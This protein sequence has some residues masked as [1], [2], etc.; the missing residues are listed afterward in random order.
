MKFVLKTLIAFFIFAG[1]FFVFPLHNAYAHDPGGDCS[2]TRMGPYRCDFFTVYKCAN[3]SC[4]KDGG[5]ID[6][7]TKWYTCENYRWEG[8]GCDEPHDDPPRKVGGPYGPDNIHLY[9]SA[10]DYQICPASGNSWGLVPNVPPPAYQCSG[11][12]YPAPEIT[13]LDKVDAIPE[14]VFEN[15]KEDGPIANPNNVKLPAH[16]SWDDSVEKKLAESPNPHPNTALCK[17]DSYE[18]VIPNPKPGQTELK[19]KT[20]RTNN[21]DVLDVDNNPDTVPRDVIISKNECA[22]NSNAQYEFTVRACLNKEC[23]DKQDT[24]LSFKTSPAPQLLL[25]FDEDFQGEKGAPTPFPAQFKWCSQQDSSRKS[26]AIKAYELKNG[27]KNHL[28]INDLSLQKDQTTY[29]DSSR[30]KEGFE[31]FEKGARYFWKIGACTDSRATQCGI[32]SQLWSIITEGKL[33]APKNLLPASSSY[34]N[35]NDVLE[36]TNPVFTTNFVIHLTGADLG[37]KFFIFFTN[38]NPR[39]SLKSIWPDLLLDRVYGWKV[40]PCGGQPGSKDIK[41]CEDKD[42]TIPWSNQSLFIVTG[43]IPTHPI[44]ISEESGVASIPATLDWDDMGGAASYYYKIGPNSGVV[45]KSQV[46]IEY[47][48]LKPGTSYLWEV[49]T[50]A[51]TVGTVC[52]LPAT[53]SFTT[54][55]LVPPNITFPVAG[56]TDF[57]P[58]TKISWNKIFSGNSYQYIL[59]F[60]LPSPQEVSPKCKTPFEAEKRTVSENSATVRLRCLGNYNLTV[61]ACVDKECKEAS[62]TTTQSLTVEKLLAP[63]GGLTICDR[64]NDNPSTKFLDERDPCELKHIF[65]LIKTLIDFALWKLIPI[66]A[67]LYAILTGALF[68]FSLGDVATI[69]KVKSIWKAFGIGVLIMLFAWVSLNLLLG[70]LGFNITFY[71]HWFKI[72]T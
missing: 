45:T 61:K 18:Y 20:D 2:R 48:N 69:R 54:A 63:S 37:D 67:A 1:V 3:N 50:C 8:S 62:Q 12:C 11:I 38:Q 13:P 6:Q 16:F 42:G 68:Y 30:G 22:L 41:N 24:P 57:D 59:A 55:T 32:F 60:G 49:K 10:G 25:P 33:M 15:A 47:P 19:D 27:E 14:N 44:I 40:A 36:W 64:G 70:L 53:G 56:Q 66:F 46:T 5:A 51:D 29:D 9:T 52:G 39:L 58:S 26:Y 17:V 65:L 71:G 23:G 43:A 28:S 35:M 34:V 72:K 31:Q 7:G 4:G 21:T